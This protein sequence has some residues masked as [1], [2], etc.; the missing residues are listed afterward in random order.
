MPDGA[1]ADDR[2]LVPPVYPAGRRGKSA[3]FS[4]KKEIEMSKL[5]IV[6]DGEPEN[7]AKPDPFSLDALRLGPA[8]EKIAGVKKVLS[9]VPVRKPHDQE[10]FWVNSAPS[11][12]LISGPSSSKTRASFIWLRLRLRAITSRGETLHVVY[13]RQHLWCRHIVARPHFDI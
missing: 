5:E 7:S 9:I 2:A 8:F 10:W 6:T 13:V 4:E 12:G 11:I 1:G 3:A